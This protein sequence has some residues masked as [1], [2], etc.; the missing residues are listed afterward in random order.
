MLSHTLPLF[1]LES[2]AVITVRLE[3]QTL[4]GRWGAIPVSQLP[5]LHNQGERPLLLMCTALR[6]VSF[7]GRQ[8]CNWTLALER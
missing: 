1:S 6:W 4:G 2:Q 8:G 3:V 5:Q 7:D